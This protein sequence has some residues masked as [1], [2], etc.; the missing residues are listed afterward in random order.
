MAYKFER[1]THQETARDQLDELNQL[2][3]ELEHATNALMS[4]R[5]SLE[6]QSTVCLATRSAFTHFHSLSV[7][8]GT[9]EQTTADELRRLLTVVVNTLPPGKY[10]DSVEARHSD[11][12]AFCTDLTDETHTE[13]SIDTDV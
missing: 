4:N 13:G 8:E 7:I 11:F 2:F 12:I 3:R 5:G 10:R 1:T 6:L 9:I